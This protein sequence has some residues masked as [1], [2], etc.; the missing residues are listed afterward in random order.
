MT[1]IEVLLSIVI[2]S[3][4]FAVIFRPILYG[5]SA[6]SFLNERIEAGRLADRKIWE[7]KN[8]HS[9]QPKIPKALDNGTLIGRDRVYQYSLKAKALESRRQ[10]FEAELEVFWKA[11]GRRRAIKRTFNVRTKALQIS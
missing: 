11:G 7:F 9:N 8:T 4:S 3:A 1:L 2:L 10:L 6:L 5:A